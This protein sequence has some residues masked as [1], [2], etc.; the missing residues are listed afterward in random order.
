MSFGQWKRQARLLESLRM[1]ADGQ[2]VI[3]VAMDLGY[4]N[5]S[6]FTAMFRRALGMC[7]TKYFKEQ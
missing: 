3:N 1:L 6:A 5:P 4:N 2:S 7:P